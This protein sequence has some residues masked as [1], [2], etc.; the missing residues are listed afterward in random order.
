MISSSRKAL[1]SVDDDR[2]ANLALQE[3]PRWL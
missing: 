1:Q 3:G 2:R